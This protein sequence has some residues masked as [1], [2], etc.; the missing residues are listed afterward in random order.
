M[1]TI[2]VFY[3]FEFVVLY[4]VLILFYLMKSRGRKSFEKAVASRYLLIVERIDVSGS[5]VRMVFNRKR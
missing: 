4:L 2:R 1:I 5:V 3:L